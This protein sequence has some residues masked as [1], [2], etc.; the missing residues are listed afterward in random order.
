MI[1][2]WQRHMASHSYFDNSFEWGGSVYAAAAAGGAGGY[3]GVRL[4][5]GI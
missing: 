2:E 4:G 1:L 5:L 3:I